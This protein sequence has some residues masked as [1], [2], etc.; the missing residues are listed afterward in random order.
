[1]LETRE[2][3][4]LN[5]TA[6]DLGYK[7]C[8]VEAKKF[9][10]GQLWPAGNLAGEQRRAIDALLYHLMR[11]IKLL[12]FK[13][14]DGQS[15]EV[16]Q[17][18]HDRLSHAFDN[19]FT[20][21]EDAAIVDTCRSFKIPQDLFFE[22]LH[23][24]ARW[25]RDHRF[26]TYKELDSFC[27]KIGGSTLSAAMPVLGVIN[28]GY[29]ADAHTCGKAIML[30]Q[31][32]AHCVHDIRRNKIFLAREDL[33]ECEVDVSRLKLA[34]PSKAF[35]YL[36]RLYAF[37]IEKMFNESSHLI[38][39]LDFDGKRS[40]KSLLSANWKSLMKMKIEPESILFEENV[41]TK[42]ERLILHSKHVMGIDSNL[43]IIVE[44]EEHY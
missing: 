5:S 30:T 32:L 37:R 7:N 27:G 35:R 26:N 36:V 13:S 9:F 15:L 10:K 31:L 3:I 25:I 39:H 40:L 21:V 43:P 22:P 28:R 41:L 2:Q 44:A 11:T 24:A 38:Q 23:G 1:M 20:S 19:R 33:K 16:W 8:R 42:K 34:Q 18:V 6:L 14:D 29:E 17:E 4:E 12:D